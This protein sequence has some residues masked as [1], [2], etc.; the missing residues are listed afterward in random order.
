VNPGRRIARRWHLA[1]VGLHLVVLTFALIG[2]WGHYDL[3]RKEDV[4]WPPQ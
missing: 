3:A 1:D 4:L 2:L